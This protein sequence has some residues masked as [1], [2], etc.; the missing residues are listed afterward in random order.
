MDKLDP[1]IILL[2][3]TLAVIKALIEKH[4][5]DNA[6]RMIE[7]LALRSG[8]KVERNPPGECCFRQD[9]TDSV[10]MN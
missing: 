1:E 2:N 8:G 7:D 4:G 5:A 6:W 9:L 3:Q 10:S